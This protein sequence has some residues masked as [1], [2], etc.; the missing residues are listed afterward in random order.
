MGVL[1]HGCCVTLLRMRS[2]ALKLR[3]LIKPLLI[4]LG[5]LWGLE[6]LDFFL[7]GR[8]D[9]LGILPRRTLGLRGIVFAPLLHG[10]FTHLATNT[11]PLLVLS[12]FTMLRG[13]SI[14]GWVTALV[15]LVGG[16][17]TWLFGGANTVH[18]GSSIL[19]FGYL[20]YLLASA[21]FERSMISLIIALVVGVLY[22]GM[23]FG[24]LPL[25]EGISWQ[26]HLSGL[27]GGI[28]A[29]RFTHRGKAQVVD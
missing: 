23:L 1:P 13:L 27:I 5:L 20:G 10:G 29:A 25:R 15:W 24:V 26:G 7:A 2:A 19:I 8:L 17:G 21:Y 28:L 16:A 3:T 14:F 12:F 4:M 9:Y 6:L 22:G 11:L 18:I